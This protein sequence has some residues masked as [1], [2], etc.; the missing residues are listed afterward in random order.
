MNA[1]LPSPIHDCLKLLQRR[2]L[3]VRLL[4]GF[5]LL[6]LAVCG[7]IALSFAIDFW[8]QPPL[9]V[10]VL[11]ALVATT[12]ILYFFNRLL[13]KPLR[14]RPTATQLA[15]II[16]SNF[17]L[18]DRL[19]SSIEFSSRS[20]MPGSFTEGLVSQAIAD[21]QNL[22]PQKIYK[23]KAP[24]Y[25]FS[26][27]LI[28]CAALVLCASYFPQHN[29]VFWQ[30]IFG[31][32]VNWPA[33]TR[34]IFVIDNLDP[35]Q[36]LLSS[37]SPNHFVLQTSDPGNITLQAR[38]IGKLP[39]QVVLHGLSQGHSMTPLGGGDFSY[40]L[41]PLAEH[42]TFT[43]SGGDH[44][45]ESSSLTVV[46][47]EAPILTDWQ[48]SVSPPDYTLLGNEVS[49]SQ[50]LRVIKSSV[51]DLSFMVSE[52]VLKISGTLDSGK[53]LE[54]SP[55]ESGTYAAVIDAMN[56]GSLTIKLENRAGFTSYYP[57]QLSWQ[58]YSDNA[59]QIEVLFPQRNF[60]AVVSGIMP[61]S[62]QLSDD[63]QLSLLN[64]LNN[65][66][67]ELGN[68][69]L[70]GLSDNRFFN[71]SVPE[72]DNENLN[73]NIHSIEVLVKDN[74]L[75]YPN[76]SNLYSA[77]YY[78]QTPEVAEEY[79]STQVQSLRRRLETM[80]DKLDV[81]AQLSSRASNFEVQ[82]VLDSLDTAFEQS[83]WLLCERIFSRLDS[84]P[85][86]TIQSLQRLLSSQFVA[87]QI[88]D[89]LTSNNA[90]GLVGRSSNLLQL[91]NAL[92]IARSYPA[93]DL[94]EKL[95]NNEN[96]SPHLVQLR[97]E[98]DA[99]LETIVSWEDYQS[100]V[101]LLRQLLDRQRGLYLRTQDAVQ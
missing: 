43:L 53:S 42:S 24:L 30:R 50:E 76:L 62:V 36:N 2:I 11:H 41:P 60:H 6:I 101:N 7:I 16:E 31:A 46:V 66:G 90:N 94:K 13:F 28:A 4:R 74:Q 95:L 18:D 59:P 38:A 61:L 29:A 37:T 99:I 88:V 70:Q 3:A 100:A 84:N 21:C 51:I 79:L 25:Q 96:L 65:D 98:I 72:F 17:E 71:F 52:D 35:Q 81:F 19:S 48:V 92:A 39:R 69:N 78:V 33:K 63:F 73:A 5:G 57:Q 77:N 12:A 15:A 45:I 55:S 89:M 47:G 82:R 34:L 23:V 87:G 20:L 44:H 86:S 68:I 10:R 93:A 56:S 91:A 8:L 58:V 67:D 49:S 75:P 83:E 40:S 26:G 54:L 97:S 32:D 9:T 1:T 27:A 64:L 22:A 80:R 85:D 14:H